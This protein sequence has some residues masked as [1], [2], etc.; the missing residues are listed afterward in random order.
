MRRFG[1]VASAFALVCTAQE[2]PRPRTLREASKAMH[3]A[4][5]REVVDGDVRGAVRDYTTIAA[6]DDANNL[7]RWIAVARLLELQRLGV[8]VP[9]ASFEVAAPLPLRA[10]LDAAKAR[11]PV[12][13]EELLRRATQAPEQVMQ[14]VS[15]EIG[16]LPTLRPATTSAQEW[17]RERLRSR[18]FDRRPRQGNG[19][20][21]RNRPDRARQERIYAADILQ[22]E[23][24]GRQE[25]AASLSLLCFADWKTP[26]LPKDPLDAIARVRTGIEAWIADKDASQAQ[27]RL[28]RELR[29]AFDQRAAADPSA[30]LAFLARLPLYAD[31]L[32]GA[33]SG[34]AASKR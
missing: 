8:A 14:S 2:A 11:L 28:L 6:N 13:V 12:P 4:W 16:R 30:A 5:L 25:Q 19:P 29:E 27:Q 9:G 22:C 20:G 18:N 1:F 3:L 17:V 26:A 23:L 34:A 10:A 7:Q 15:S 33:P 31:R 21:N 32:L 24:Q